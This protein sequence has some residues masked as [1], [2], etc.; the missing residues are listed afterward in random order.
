MARWNLDLHRSSVAELE[1]YS[2]TLPGTSWHL[3]RKVLHRGLRGLHYGRH[4]CYLRGGFGADRR[5][6]Q[7]A[8]VSCRRRDVRDH[9][10]CGLSRGYP[11]D[12]YD[13]ALTDVHIRLWRLAC[14]AGPLTLTPT[15]ILALAERPFG[16]HGHGAPADTAC[17]A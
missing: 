11:V 15:L 2:H 1:L 9:S 13:R 12:G 7:F 6:L 4:L 3:E 14:G 5:K 16:D 17:Y 10:S 8:R